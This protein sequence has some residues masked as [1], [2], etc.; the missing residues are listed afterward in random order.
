M[1]EA[2]KTT[3]AKKS[4][5]GATSGKRTTSGTKGRSSAK[6]SQTAKKT[7][8]SKKQPARQQTK[9]AVYDFPI[10]RE[11]AVLVCIALAVI[12]FISSFDSIDSDL[13]WL[14]Q[15]NFGLFGWFGYA[16][17]LVLIF[18]TLFIAANLDHFGKKPKIKCAG[19]VLLTVAC[20]ALLQDIQIVRFDYTVSPQGYFTY[21]YEH[22]GGGMIGGM[23]MRLFYPLLG[24][25]GSGVLLFFLILIGL[26]IV[27][28]VSMQDVA[29]WIRRSYET[30]Q[31][32]QRAR[33][34]VCGGIAAAASGRAGSQREKG[35]REEDHSCGKCRSEE[36]RA[37]VPQ[38]A[39]E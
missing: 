21:G 13:G 34:P 6:Q 32:R 4:S 5:S 8:A 20:C 38:A 15:L 1:A 28:E 35:S 17:A 10:A 9:T 36:R 22:G 24:Q 23:V 11:I 27:T 12:L 30:H 29:K 19:V 14:K 26:M 18:L 31:E 33:S 7:T 16:S 25:I 2:K 37:G 3:R 39:A